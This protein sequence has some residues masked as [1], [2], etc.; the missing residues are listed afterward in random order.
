M[1]IV[2]S[3]IWQI[4]KPLYTPAT[5]FRVAIWV[6]LKVN[7]IGFTQDCGRQTIPTC[8]IQQDSAVSVFDCQEIVFGLSVKSKEL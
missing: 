4:L 6:E 1:S 2:K 5:L 8:G 3:Y 7:Q